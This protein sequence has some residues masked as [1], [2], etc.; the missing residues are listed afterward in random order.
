MTE[1]KC[2]ECGIAFPI[3]ALTIS[4][5]SWNCKGC[6]SEAEKVNN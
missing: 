4:N 2:N 6:L 5:D 3:E 1:K